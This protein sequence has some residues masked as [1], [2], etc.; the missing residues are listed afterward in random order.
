[1]FCFRIWAGYSE[2]CS[3]VKRSVK[4]V[5]G[6]LKKDGRLRSYQVSELRL[7]C[8]TTVSLIEC[9]ESLSWI[10]KW[11]NEIRTDLGFHFLATWAVLW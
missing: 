5:L 3:C 10:F 9:K 11:G 6:S 7:R 8:N 4:G 1:M 2:V